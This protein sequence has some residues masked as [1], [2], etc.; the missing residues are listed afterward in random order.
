MLDYLTCVVMYLLG[1][2]SGSRDSTPFIPA[3]N[4][5]CRNQQSTNDVTKML[6]INE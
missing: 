3:D 1:N 5:A 2:L 4:N 6:K